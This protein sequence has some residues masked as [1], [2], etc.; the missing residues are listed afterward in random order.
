M[1]DLTRFISVRG[2]SSESQGLS[3]KL[4]LQE[5]TEIQ[6]RLPDRLHISKA[7][8]IDIQNKLA[9]VET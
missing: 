1:K 9:A 6:T 7:W 8:L 4:E 2:T 5:A 3:S